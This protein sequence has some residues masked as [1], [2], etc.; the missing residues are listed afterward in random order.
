MLSYQHEFHAGNFA[1]VHKH[2]M[3]WLL[4]ENMLAK[5]KPYSVVDLYAGSGGY[6]LTQGPAARAQEW[7][8]GI[9]RLRPQPQF[10]PELNTFLRSVYGPDPVPSALSYYPG[11]PEWVR[12]RLRADDRLHAC[13]LHPQAYAALRARFHSDPRCHIHKRDARE[14]AVGLLPPQPRRGLILLDPPYERQQE[15]TEVPAM[16]RAIRER[17]QTGIVLLWYP[18]LQDGLAPALR[19]TLW[20]QYPNER[21]LLSELRLSEPVQGHGLQ[22]SGLLILGAPWQFADRVAQNLRPVWRALDPENQGGLFQA[23][24]L[25]NVAGR[26]QLVRVG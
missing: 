2:L 19:T 25:E 22:G 16:V 5:P 6:D 4:L 3:L 15:Y 7:R 18:L 8:R 26:P 12:Q 17:W 11:S 9:G 23:E 13:E 1:D 21:R 20:E 24:G 14:A 10:P